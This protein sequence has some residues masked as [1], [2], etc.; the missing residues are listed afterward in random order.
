MEL[1]DSRRL[2]GPNL[3]LDGPGAVLDVAVGA[4]E[5]SA[6]SLARVR[7]ALL[8]WL[9]DVGW[10]DALVAGRAWPAGFSLAVCAPIDA[11]YAATEV[12]EA[13][14]AEASRG[15]L[16]PPERAAEVARLRAAIE[17]ERQPARRALFAAARARG[18]NVC[19]DDQ[20]TTVGMGTGSRTWPNAELP[21]ADA[22][23]WSAVHDVPCALV[24]GTNG[25]STTVRLVAAMARAAGLVPGASSTDW[26]QV[27]E[28]LVDR[29]DWSGPGGARAVLRDA[30]VEL[31]VLETARGGL[32]R[33]GLA[34]PRADV[35]VI[36]N[37]GED[38]LGEMGVHDLATLTEL[39]FTVRRAAERLVLNADDLRLRE[40]GR[41][42]ERP[43]TWFT[44]EPLAP[45]LAEHV[46]RGGSAAVVEDGTLS[47]LEAGER[48]PLLAVA[49]VPIA[50]G[51][52]ARFNVSNALA[53][54]AAALHLGL[55]LDAVRAGLAGF[56]SDAESNP[57]RMNLFELGGARALV[58]FA[59]NPHGLRALLAVARELP[60]ERLLVLLGQAGD[61]SDAAIE[62]LGRLVA[63][64]APDLVVVKHMDEHRR[65]RPPG[66]VVRLI[67]AALAAGGLYASSVEEAPSELAG[68]RRALAWARPGDLL[69]LLSHAERGAVL[70]EVAARAGQARLG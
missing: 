2:T 26:I 18:L 44:R 34:I 58:D 28:A 55:P 46:A 67:R 9:A 4:G 63:A 13:A 61:R 33:R 12:T 52:A 27:G 47:W 59:H 23:D 19:G 37:V 8:G 68:V 49:D 10:A 69:L 16:P 51:G 36:T 6:S 66:E 22:V 24:T 15:P 11:L 17:T 1:A 57:G 54:A 21:E 29:D 50:L 14:F 7:E 56:T 65:G 64:A 53:A 25:K 42:V 40:R 41:S 5:R 32:L 20:S 70:A 43:V 35:A 30:R 60:H 38:H 39:K 48:H 62:E 31:A 3:Y 45:W